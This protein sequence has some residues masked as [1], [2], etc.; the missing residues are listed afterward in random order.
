MH[1]STIVNYKSIDQHLQLSFYAMSNLI[2]ASPFFETYPHL[3]RGLLYL[4]AGSDVFLTRFTDGLSHPSGRTT[5]RLITTRFVWRG[6]NKD[7]I[8]WAK[9]CLAC[10]RAKIHYHV[11]PRLHCP[12]GGRCWITGY[13]VWGAH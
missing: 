3:R 10:Q 7:I 2:M 11:C 5:R 8:A 12:V 6:I 13:P 4:A 9:T 1:R